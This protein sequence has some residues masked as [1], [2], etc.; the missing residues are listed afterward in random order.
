MTEN[1]YESPQEAGHVS[2]ATEAWKR[3]LKDRIALVVCGFL[4]TVLAMLIFLGLAILDN[5]PGR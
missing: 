1:P 3:W 4:V 5:R 2:P